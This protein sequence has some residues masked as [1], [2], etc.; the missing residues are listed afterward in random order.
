[1][2]LSVILHPFACLYVG[3]SVNLFLFMRPIR[4]ESRFPP[5]KPAAFHHVVVGWRSRTQ[6]SFMKSV[7]WRGWHKCEIFS[8]VCLRQTQVLL[9]RTE[10]HLVT[11]Q[12]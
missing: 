3:V 10:S 8:F 9:P 7:I 12:V 6:R 2:R 1:M 5:H 11:C 4:P